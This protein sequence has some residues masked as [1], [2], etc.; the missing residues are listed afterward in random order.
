MLV[1]CLRGAGCGFFFFFFAL[2]HSLFWV[3]C[4]FRVPLTSSIAPNLYPRKSHTLNTKLIPGLLDLCPAG[5]FFFLFWAVHRSF[6]PEGWS[7]VRLDT[8][9]FNSDPKPQDSDPIP[10]H[11]VV[12]NPTEPFAHCAGLIRLGNFPLPSAGRLPNEI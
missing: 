3:G 12:H 7:T 6:L 10:Q 9:V 4:H 2:K 11:N 5:H 8:S 1:R